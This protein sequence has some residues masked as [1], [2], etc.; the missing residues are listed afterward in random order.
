MAK[1]R[2]A[3]EHSIVCSPIAAVLLNVPMASVC[4]GFDLELGP[5]VAKNCQVHVTY[6]TFTSVHKDPV[7]L[8]DDAC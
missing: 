6:T 3:R 8:L 1:L 2:S 5:S 4:S 7:S